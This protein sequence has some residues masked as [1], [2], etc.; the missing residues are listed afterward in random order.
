MI[1]RRMLDLLAECVVTFLSCCSCLCC[2]LLRFAG[3]MEGVEEVEEVE[4]KVRARV[5]FAF[6]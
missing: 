4:A 3:G 2:L 1:L 5:V 6:S